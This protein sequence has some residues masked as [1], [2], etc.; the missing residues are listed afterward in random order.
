MYGSG[1]K[2]YAAPSTHARSPAHELTVLALTRIKKHFWFETSRWSSRNRTTNRQQTNS[3]QARRAR[4]TLGST[5]PGLQ[6]PSRNPLSAGTEKLL[7]Q[8]GRGGCIPTQEDRS[9]FVGRARAWRGCAL[10]SEVALDR[11]VWPAGLLQRGRRAV[12][13]RHFLSS[14]LI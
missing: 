12:P 11:S 9:R 7:E 2:R 1:L 8:T 10:W 13:H 6:I 4:G 14:H 5:E 3:R